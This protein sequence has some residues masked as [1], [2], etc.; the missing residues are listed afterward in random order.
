ME[1][2]ATFR[3]PDHEYGLQG[4][5]NYAKCAACGSL[6]IQRMPSESELARFYPPNYHSFA[7]EGLLARMRHSARASRIES[8][9]RR[10]PE[11][12]LDYGCGNGSFLHYLAE[13]LPGAVL[14]GFELGP[15]F[16]RSTSADGRITI[17]RGRPHHVTSEVPHVDVI[18]LNHVIEHLPNPLEIV[19]RLNSHLR[20]NGV[21]EGQTP[22]ADSFE[23]KVFGRSWSGFHAPRHTVIF[24]KVGL[25]ALLMRAGFGAPNIRPAFNPAGIAVSLASVMHGDQAGII[26]RSGWKWM[27]FLAGA[28]ILYPLDRLSRQPGI[29]DF[30]ARRLLQ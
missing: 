26:R 1:A 10:P 24:S 29:V 6:Y 22:A 13:R 9:L 21:I 19:R 3:V 15:H 20:T 12:V 27:L 8:V 4:L 7:S 17:V 16:E 30:E 25:K 11:A 14:W 2:S 5:T 23:A 18:T 28:T